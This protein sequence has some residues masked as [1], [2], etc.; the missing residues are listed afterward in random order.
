M[1]GFRKFTREDFADLLRWIDNPVLL[2]QWAGTLFHFPLDEVQLEDYL[3]SSE[4]KDANRLIFTAYDTESGKHTGHIELNNIDLKN[5]SAC[6][7]RVLV[8]P[9]ECRGLG[10]GRE[11]LNKILVTGFN[12]LKLHRIE[13]NVF[14][15]NAP[16]IACYE[17]AGFIREGLHRDIR[18]IGDEYWSLYRMSILEEE[19][20]LKN[21]TI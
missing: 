19:W 4:K 18:R 5:G 13:L 20:K 21:P 17:K 11:M 16:A 10:I 8:G 6:I 3:A 2:Y 12:Q 9:P 1:T 7:C 14:D 15:F